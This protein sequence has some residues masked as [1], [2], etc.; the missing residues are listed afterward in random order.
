MKTLFTFLLVATYLPAGVYSAIYA[1]GASA[2]NSTYPNAAPFD[3]ASTQA[4]WAVQFRVHNFSA[5][6]GAYSARTIFTINTS[7]T[8]DGLW[9]SIDASS[10]LQCA[11]NYDANGGVNILDVSVWTDFVVTINR[12]SSSW[13]VQA[14][15]IQLTSCL[16]SS[17]SVITPG[18]GRVTSIVFGATNTN[19][20]VAYWRYWTGSKS[21][22]PREY[23]SLTGAR[24][25]YEFEN[26]LSDSSANAQNLTLASGAI[27]YATTPTYPPGCSA[28]SQQTLRSGFSGTLDGTG[29]LA[30]DSSST[31]NYFWTQTSGPSTAAWSSRT[32]SVPVVSRL[33]GGTYVFQLTV[34][35]GDGQSTT[36]TITDGAV[37]TDTNSVVVTGNSTVDELVGPVLKYGASPW[38]FFDTADKA[39]ADMLGARQGATQAWSDI[40]NTALTGT[41]TT[42]NSS[43]TVTGSGTTFQATFCGGG[44]SGAGNYLVIWYDIDS[45]TFTFGPGGAKPTAPAGTGRKALEVTACASDTSLTISQAWPLTTASGLSYAK[46]TSS[47]VQNWANGSG[48][49][50]YYD[51]V[52]AF[53]ALQYRSGLTTYTPYATWLAD[54]W[55]YSPFV[56]RCMSADINLGFFS[57]QPRLRSQ[58]GMYLYAALTSNTTLLTNLR[59]CVSNSRYTLSV[60][61][62][63][64]P[65]TGFIGDIRENAYEL[66]FV[67]L[68]ALYDPDSSV[69]AQCLAQIIQEIDNRW[70][71]RRQP[72]GHWD[73]LALGF[74][75]WNGNA[76]GTVAVVNGGTTVT[77]TGVNWDAPTVAA[78]PHFWTTDNPNGLSTTG[79]QTYYTATYVD[80]THLTISPAYQGVTQ[81][82][83]QWMLSPTWVGYGT[84]PFILGIAGFAFRLARL[85]FVAAGDTAHA[86]TMATWIQGVGDWVESTSGGYQSARRGLW[87]GVGFQVCNPP[88]AG[89]TNVCESPDGVEGTRYLNGEIMNAI[90]TTYLLSPNGTRLTA[91]DNLFSAVFADTASDPGY[92]GTWVTELEPTSFAFANGKS[93]N[94]GFFWGIGGATM[95]GAARVGGVQPADTVSYSQECAIPTGLYP[96]AAKLRVTLKS[97]TGST[98]ISTCTSGTLSLSV[99]RRIA[100]SGVYLRKVDVLTSGDVQ[101]TAG[102]WQAVSVQ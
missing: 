79:D 44:S 97:P 8:A 96:T 54:K 100:A 74:S 21:S 61:S 67:S 37:A 62:V 98:A 86:A 52:L 36:C 102:D 93:K 63:T 82:G 26:N 90:S 39:W 29:S 7:T 77:G 41:I 2:S 9:C 28:G 32:S 68:C 56:D 92:D 25:A 81:S 12:S 99:D 17:A 87:Y 66:A 30:L 10:M 45:Q 57:Q 53:Y 55:F 15:V 59:T 38:S 60:D 19:L 27:T 43:A 76:T 4:T 75:T 49:I 84:Q 23:D 78:N 83:R 22:P 42:T 94:F 58:V 18:L 89:G 70:S 11:N 73:F 16:S 47:D 20:R 35:Q 33:S 71:P 51:N 1:P 50:N 72:D 65:G 14:C 24:L 85:A 101:I 6:S 48:N 95:W 91:G 13:S 80:A 69:R 40:W 64:P 88:V 3:A 5:G 34:T 46:M 31:L